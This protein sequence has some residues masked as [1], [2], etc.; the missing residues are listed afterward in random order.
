MGVW[1]LWSRL[2]SGCSPYLCR[3]LQ[4][5]VHWFRTAVLSVRMSLL[6]SSMTADLCFWLLVRALRVLFITS[7]PSL[8]SCTAPQSA[9]SLLPS[10]SSWLLCSLFCTLVLLQCLCISVSAALSGRT[11]PELRL[12]PKVEFSSSVSVNYGK[13]SCAALPA[14]PFIQ[15]TILS[16]ALADSN[17]ALKGVHT[18][19][20]SSDSHTDIEEI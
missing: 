6:L 7:F 18:L 9:L 3:S 15:P 4:Y 10:S 2:V 14:H 20:T 19:I 16:L 12:W 17:L 11:D 1:L 5:S 8:C 13:K